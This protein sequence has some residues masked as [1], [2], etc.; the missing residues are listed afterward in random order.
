MELNSLFGRRRKREVKA[1]RLES[2][3]VTDHKCIAEDFSRYFSPFVGELDMGVVDSEC[4]LNLPECD[5]VFKFANVEEEEVL[6]LLLGLDI[7]NAMGAD[8]KLLQIAAPGVSGSLAVLFNC[9]LQCGKVPL[10]W[11]SAVLKGG[12]SED[13]GNYRPVSVL[14]VIV[15][16][17]E[18]LLHQQLYRYLQIHSILYLGLGLSISL[19]MWLLL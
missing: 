5:H 12:N 16:I 4:V 7:S 18:R 6:Q 11:K 19:K 14:P 3:L 15:K 8:A 10:E 1:V 13:V 17:F 2:G 9:S